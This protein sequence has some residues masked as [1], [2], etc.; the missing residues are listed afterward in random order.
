MW[1]DL[2]FRQDTD[3]LA[4][5]GNYFHSASGPDS[6]MHTNKVDGRISRLLKPCILKAAPTTDQWLQ[7]LIDGKFCN[8]SQLFSRLMLNRG[9]CGLINSA[10]P[11]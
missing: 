4:V 10:S 1:L 9:T 2:Q 5:F 11:T 6:F 3:Q 7:L 8:R